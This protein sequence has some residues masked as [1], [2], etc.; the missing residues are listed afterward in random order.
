MR[1][2]RI[3]IFSTLAIILLGVVLLN[4]SA[5][6][7][8]NPCED[9]LYVAFHRAACAEI[10]GKEIRIIEETLRQ[11]RTRLAYKAIMEGAKGYPFKPLP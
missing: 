7:G 1:I 2:L 4:I 11:K 5:A 9:S 8:T 6:D 3:L 10:A